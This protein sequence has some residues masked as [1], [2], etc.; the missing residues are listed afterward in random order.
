MPGSPE[1]NRH[2]LD[3]WVFTIWTPV[4][5]AL[6]LCPIFWAARG[7]NLTAGYIVTIAIETLGALLIVSLAIKIWRDQ[8]SR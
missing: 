6:V 2:W 3:R 4:V 5:L 8:K 7:G 1:K